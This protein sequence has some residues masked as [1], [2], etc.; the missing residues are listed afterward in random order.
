MTGP[1]EQERS[2]VPNR[3]WLVIYREYLLQLDASRAVRIVENIKCKAHTILRRAKHLG[4]ADV[5]LE[6]VGD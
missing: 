2:V 4:Y 6:H 3:G 5:L 1:Y